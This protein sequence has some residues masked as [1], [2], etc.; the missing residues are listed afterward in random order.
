M[1]LRRENHQPMAMS[2]WENNT[3]ACG[4]SVIKTEVQTHGF[5]FTY[6][7]FTEKKPFIAYLL[8][9]QSYYNSLTNFL[10]L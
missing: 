2:H 8:F 7:S 5:K 9:F 1:S 4:G 6:L 3:E 10:N